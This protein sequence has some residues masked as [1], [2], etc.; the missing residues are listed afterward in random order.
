M[1][2]PFAVVIC[3]QRQEKGQHYH[4]I[5]Q[6]ECVAL[7]TW[8]T[9]PKILIDR[10][11]QFHHLSGKILQIG[12]YESRNNVKLLVTSQEMCPLVNGDRP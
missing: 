6:S 8:T 1:C 12:K 5:F 3:S 9:L 4:Q 7:S 10:R 2:D 11:S